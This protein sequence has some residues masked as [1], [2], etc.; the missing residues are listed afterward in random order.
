[1]FMGAH[2]AQRVDST[3]TFFFLERYHKD[4]DELLSHIVRIRGDETWV[5][6]MMLKPKSSQGSGFTHI[7][8]TSRKSL[9]TRLPGR[10]LMAAVFWDR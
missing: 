8:Q 9:N 2:K 3:L 5:S 6:F 4:G 10:K 1:M 7:Q